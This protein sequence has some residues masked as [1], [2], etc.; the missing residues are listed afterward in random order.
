MSFSGSAW[1]AHVYS[2]QIVGTTPKGSTVAMLLW[3]RILSHCI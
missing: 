3:Y 1:I 2:D